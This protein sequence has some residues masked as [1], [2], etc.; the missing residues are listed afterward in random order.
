MLKGT[1][2]GE[3]L[4]DA[5]DASAN[6]RMVDTIVPKV[7]P[8]K[9]R[10]GNQAV[11]VAP[12]LLRDPD[13][14]AYSRS[15]LA[16]KIGAKLDSAIEGLDAAADNRGVS[17]QVKTGPLL[18]QIDSAIGDLTAQPV[19]GSH[20]TPVYVGDAARQVPV[21]KVHQYALRWMKDDMDNLPFVKHTFNEQLH[22]GG[23]LEIVPGSAGAKVYDAIIGS[24][25][26]RLIQATRGEV[27]QAINDVLEGNT[28]GRLRQLVVGVADKLAQGDYRTM[29][30]M[31]TSGPLPRE[32]PSVH[33]LRMGTGKPAD[34]PDRAGAPLGQSVEPAPN[35]AQLDTLKRM[36]DEVAA[37]GP[38]ADY[39][40]VRRIRSA[41]DQVAKVK[42]SP[43]VSPDYLAKQGEAT[44]AAKGTSAMREALANADSGTAQAN[45]TYHLY[46][47]ANDVIQAAE[48]ADRVR[49]NRGRG[50]MA[51][52]AGAMIGAESG[53]AVGAGIGAMVATIADKAAEMAPTFQIAI[54][55]RLAAVADALRAGETETAQ[56]LVDR[57]VARFPAVKTTLKITGKMTPA[58]ASGSGLPLAAG[59]HEKTP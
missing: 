49:P 5:A 30:M 54:A 34:L 18:K 37:L 17:T 1:S 59:G 31:E 51:R 48:Q 6:R 58:M 33:T 8:N 12:K 23:D 28:D 25:D 9:L 7:G 38:V 11:D 27:R 4:A 45:E 22:H 40:A 13:L 29:K 57:T 32:E 21:D 53:G 24:E 50:I 56:A 2:L 46:K 19:E 35:R 16:D 20:K 15:G 44:G 47:T 14:S 43:A 36:R 10:M 26:Q 41:W 55:R 42:Y 39:E 52:T 3:G